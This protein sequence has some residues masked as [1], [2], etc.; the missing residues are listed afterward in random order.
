MAR[1]LGA[2]LS[3]MGTSCTVR[4][5]TQV[6]VQVKH[7]ITHA[8]H[9][10]DQTSP[11]PF[12]KHTS[13][14][15]CP[16]PP[17]PTP[18]Y[19]A[20]PSLHPP[21]P[22]PPHPTPPH[23]TPPHSQPTLHPPHP[24]PPHPTPPQPTH[25]PRLQHAG[26]QQPIQLSLLGHLLLTQH[27]GWSSSREGVME[28]KMQAYQLTGPAPGVEGQCWLGATNSLRASS[29]S[30]CCCASATPPAGIPGCKRGAQGQEQGKVERAH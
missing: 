5:T 28:G 16:T 10:K 17:H 26:L 19:P 29:M 14:P 7:S 22:T 2:A 3:G 15:T 30:Q 9:N 18:P 4:A 24:T 1:M 20:P 6:S 21:H 12:K 11:A 13:S 25:L 27:L 23:P 8:C